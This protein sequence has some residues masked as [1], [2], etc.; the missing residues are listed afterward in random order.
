M[1]M[2]KRSHN[3]QCVCI[4]PIITKFTCSQRSHNFQCVRITP[5]ITKFVFSNQ[6]I[7][8]CWICSSVR[9]FGLSPE[10]V[11]LNLQWP[12]FFFTLLLI[13]C[14]RCILESPCPSVL[15]VCLGFVRMIPPE[16]LNLFV[17][18]GIVCICRQFLRGTSSAVGQDDGYLSAPA[19]SGLPRTPHQ[20]GSCVPCRRGWG[21][22][23]HLAT[24]GGYGLATLRLWRLC[25]E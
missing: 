3:F 16:A 5:I 13:F 14:N 21:T 15:S 25:L 17:P 10:D 24:P 2:E 22:M 20:Q 23:C 12:N 6:S 4:T 1:E 18:Y 9:V 7:S 11:C 19:P 8:Q